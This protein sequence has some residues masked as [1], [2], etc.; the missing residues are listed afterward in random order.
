MSD[1]LKRRTA[2]RRRAANLAA[3]LLAAACV[4]PQA[5]HGL[6][7]AERPGGLD[8]LGRAPDRSASYWISPTNAGKYRLSAPG[9]VSV[10]SQSARVSDLSIWDAGLFVSCS[11]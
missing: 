10:G 7:C 6:D 5:S 4:V 8:Q 11:F 9:D 3:G 1:R 2:A